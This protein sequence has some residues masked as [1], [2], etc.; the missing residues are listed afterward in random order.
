[1]SLDLHPFLK[2]KKKVSNVSEAKIKEGIFIGLQ[3]RYHEI[4]I[5]QDD[6]YFLQNI[7][8]TENQYQGKWSPSKLGD[9]F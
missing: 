9:Y 4:L 8:S 6:E 3:I 2:I 1:M 5:K 7:V